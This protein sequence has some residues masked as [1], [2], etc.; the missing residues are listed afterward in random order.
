MGSDYGLRNVPCGLLATACSYTRC[1]DPPG[2]TA[3]GINTAVLRGRR[4]RLLQAEMQ[5]KKGC[6]DVRG[7]NDGGPC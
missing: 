7:C 2:D 5:T 3:D 6:L 4:G 1:M